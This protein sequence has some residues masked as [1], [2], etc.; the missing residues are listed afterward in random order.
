[1][2]DYFRL[3]MSCENILTGKIMD[4]YF[5]A[6]IGG[7]IIGIS[8][9]LLLLVSGR[10]FGVSGIIGGMFSADS[11]ADLH[12]RVA[13]FL[14]LVCSGLFVFGFTPSNFSTDAIGN[15]VK[16]MLAGILVGYGSRLGSGCTSGHGVC[17]IS[18]FSLRSLVATAVFIATGVMTVA[19]LG[20]AS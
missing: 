17:G 15:P 18:R 13:V 6:L 14:G 16:T 1:M 10:I 3:L 9:A 12:W 4:I 2:R 20:V 7:T 11:A 5:P 8:S 19:V